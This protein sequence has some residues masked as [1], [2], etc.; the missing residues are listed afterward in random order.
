MIAYA[1]GDE[2]APV[3]L[4]DQFASTAGYAGF[5]DWVETLG[6]DYVALHELSED[7]CAD[8]AELEEELT[9]ALS[10][11]PGKPSADVLGVARA[12]RDAVRAAPTGT[13]SVG[14]TDG[15]A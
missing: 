13:A 7:G 11:K 2:D 9:R 1:P 14:V 10:E 3:E 6:A 8:L 4:G 5:L 12:L 15:E